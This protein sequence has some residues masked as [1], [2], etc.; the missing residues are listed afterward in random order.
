MLGFKLIHFS[1]ETPGYVCTVPLST[2]NLFRALSISAEIYFNTYASTSF[3][4][5]SITNLLSQI[6]RN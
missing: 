4:I 5:R 6:K 1:N 2:Q 3:I